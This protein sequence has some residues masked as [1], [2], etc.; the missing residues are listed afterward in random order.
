VNATPTVSIREREV[1]HLQSPELPTA[2]ARLAQIKA[3]VDMCGIDRLVTEVVIQT[4]IAA[5]GEAMKQKNAGAVVSC[6]RQL[7]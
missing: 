1:G 6:V 3:E 7:D 4:L 2:E 5:A